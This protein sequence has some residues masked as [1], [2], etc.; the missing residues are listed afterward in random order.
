MG[1]QKQSLRE[2]ERVDAV[3]ESL[4][5]FCVYMGKGKLGLN[6]SNRHL[7]SLPSLI[8]IDSEIFFIRMSF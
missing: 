5:S 4:S 8:T 2:H 7:V 3:H 1:F 6:I